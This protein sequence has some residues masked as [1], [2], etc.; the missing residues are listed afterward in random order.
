MIALIFSIIKIETY[1]LLS[2]ETKPN[3]R[4]LFHLLTVTARQICQVTTETRG[5][6][7]ELHAAFARRQHFTELIKHNVRE[8]V[9]RLIS[10]TLVMKTQSSFIAHEVRHIKVGHITTFMLILKITM[11]RTFSAPSC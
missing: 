6:K 11:I 2:E 4:T 10:K 1:L 7:P 5:G 8:V 3:F 9:L